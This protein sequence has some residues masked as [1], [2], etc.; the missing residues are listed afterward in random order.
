MTDSI[1]IP[2]P[3]V[4]NAAAQKQSIS[5]SLLLQTTCIFWLLAKIIGWKIWLAE[6]HF[7]VIPPF[8]FLY[9]PSIVHW[10]FF[11]SSIALL[12]ALV[13]KPNNKT[14][15]LV[16]LISEVCSCLLDQNRWQPWEYQ[17][18]FI[19]FTFLIN[20]KQTKY[21]TPSLAVMMA[22]IY[23]Y[24]G[25]GKLNTGFL[26]LVWDNMILDQFLHVKGIYTQ[27]PLVYKAGYCLGLMEML[28]GIGLLF[29]KT[30]KI[31]ALFLVF[32]HVFVLF[33]IGPAG[34]RYNIIIWP[35]NIV[36]ILHLWL[37]FIY[38]DA[39]EINLGA[40]WKSS[41]KLLLICWGILPA[42]NYA[43]LWDNYLS[44]KLYAG[45][46]PN[47]VFHVKDSTE[48]KLLKPYLNKGDKTNMNA[49]STIVVNLQVWA[50]NETNVP[51]YPEIRV[52][53]KVREQWIK[54]HPGSN[55]K[56]ILLQ[57]I[58][59]KEVKVKE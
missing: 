25:F 33:F 38:E 53:K 45:T 24:S 51:P 10:I 57:T 13:V 35:W 47:A 23:F 29:P 5:I 28:G 30:Q 12:C 16:L 48:Q 40:I 52:Y 34:I 50:M 20:A 6:R 54:Q 43:G 2:S 49:Y 27:H 21:I 44:S 19:L 41:N 56:L 42:L 31:A 7:P 26:Y 32:M 3:Q 36:M 55:T 46:L 9:V 22:A 39:K 58:G 4:T 11:V 1:S 14:I 37:L 59:R 18:I 15:L 17:Y 8:D